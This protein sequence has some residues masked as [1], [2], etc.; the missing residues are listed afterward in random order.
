MPSCAVAP[1]DVTQR[2]P[3]RYFLIHFPKRGDIAINEWLKLCK[4]NDKITCVRNSKIC[5]KHFKTDDLKED[6][7]RC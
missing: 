3:K 7:I 2:T 6:K 5:S 4:I 1:C